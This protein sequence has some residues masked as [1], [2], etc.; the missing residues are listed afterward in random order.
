MEGNKQKELA[1]ITNLHTTQPDNDQ[2]IKMTLILERITTGKKKLL[3]V[4]IYNGKNLTIESNVIGGKPI[5]ISND[6][7]EKCMKPFNDYKNIKVL[8]DMIQYKID[9]FY[10]SFK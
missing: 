3:E 9:S 6:D 7:F 1:P 4:G 10:G 8:C 2:N 5:L